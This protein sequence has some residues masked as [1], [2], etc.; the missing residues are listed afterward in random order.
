MLGENTD[1]GRAKHQEQ[2]GQI[3]GLFKDYVSRF[4]PALRID[5]LA[6]G[7]YWFGQQALDLGLI[8]E[9]LTSD[10]YLF[11]AAQRADLVRLRYELRQSP[12]DRMRTGLS[13]ALRAA[14]RELG[15]GGPSAP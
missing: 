10:E 4:R 12:A 5:E 7:E 1:A 3:H 14:L 6:T 8:D 11:A 13:G 2:L 15:L 9:V